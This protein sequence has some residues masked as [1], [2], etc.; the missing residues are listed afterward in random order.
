M[1]TLRIWDLPTRLF[2]WTLVLAVIGLVVTGS[3]G[4][5]WMNWHLRLGYLVMG[6]LV[7]RLMWGLVGGHWSRFRAFLFGPGPILAY[8]RGQA[9]LRHVAGHNPLGALSVLAMLLVLAAQVGSG[10]ISDD[11]ISFFGPLTRFV[12]NDTV[13]LATKYHKDIGKL[14][15]L[16]LVGLHVGA[17]AYYQW[18]KRQPL[19]GAMVHGDKQLGDPARHLPASADGWTQRLLALVLALG[20]GALVWWV[21]SLGMP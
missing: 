16:G 12:S 14:L 18:V 20:S 9:P 8:L 15:I 11:E 13:A 2:H 1:H 5:S 7:F 4:G 17:I 10:L 3:V 19:I 21:V 6:L